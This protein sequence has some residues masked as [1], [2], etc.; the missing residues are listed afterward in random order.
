MVKLLWTIKMYSHIECSYAVRVYNATIARNSWQQ[1]HTVRKVLCVNLTQRI[2]RQLVMSWGFESSDCFH[3]KELIALKPS[4]MVVYVTANT[5][6][7]PQSLTHSLRHSEKPRTLQVA[8]STACRLFI[9]FSAINTPY[10]MMTPAHSRDDWRMWKRGWTMY[11]H[12]YYPH[13]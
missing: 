13:V 12:K 5:T 3:N 1:W 11:I 6:S 9:F 7:E 10:P 4:Q 2:A 8:I